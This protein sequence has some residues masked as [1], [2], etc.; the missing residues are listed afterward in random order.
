MKE[1]SHPF[2]V[3]LD[4]VD[5]REF[6]YL[7]PLEG[8]E[9]PISTCC[10]PNKD[11]GQRYIYEQNSVDSRTCSF[12]LSTE[13]TDPGFIHPTPINSTRCASS[14]QTRREYPP[15]T[16]I[17][18]CYIKSLGVSSRAFLV[19]SLLQWRGTVETSNSYPD[20]ARAVPVCSLIRRGCP[21]QTPVKILQCH[22]AILF[23]FLSPS[24]RFLRL[25]IALI[26]SKL[27]IFSRNSLFIAMASSSAMSCKYSPASFL[28][29]HPL[30]DGG[31]CSSSSSTSKQQQTSFH[32]TYT[33]T[34]PTLT[35]CYYYHLLSL[36]VSSIIFHVF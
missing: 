10:S 5:S 15:E 20:K 24:S 3:R 4:G 30:F 18:S 31:A 12:F 34:R 6:V 16:N 29:T 27:R 8:D 35:T 36:H 33:H 25:C 28:S 17:K 26:S 7:K 21:G 13:H 14:I 23:F 32:P 19:N 11:Y 9:A 2:W 22:P 1:S